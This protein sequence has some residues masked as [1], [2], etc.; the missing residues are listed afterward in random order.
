M[1]TKEAACGLAVVGTKRRHCVVLRAL[2][3]GR[4]L[5]IGGSSQFHDGRPA[6]L[7]KLRSPASAALRLTADTYFYA[8]N[9]TRVT[10][11]TF[12]AFGVPC[13]PEIFHKLLRLIGLES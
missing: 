2:P 8:N 1:T 10:A 9:T 12:D 3:D 4:L 5:V 6:V 11:S 7:V 13:P